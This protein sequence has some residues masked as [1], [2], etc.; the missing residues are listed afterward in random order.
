MAT[1]FGSPH[2]LALL[3]TSHLVNDVL[4]DFTGWVASGAAGVVEGVGTILAATSAVPL[5]AS[6]DVVYDA[7]R[8]VGLAFGLLFV[9]AAVIQAVLRQDLGLLV[10]TLT[11]RLPLALLA[12]GIAIWLVQQALAITD[13]LSAMVL[14]SATGTTQQ[15]IDEL[16][17]LLSGPFSST[18]GF[19]GLLL[20]V[21]AAVVAFILSVELVMR[22]AAV[23][24]AS[25]FLP[26]A[27]AG[28]I[29]PATSHW[30]RRL[31]E[32]IASLVLAKLVIASVLALAIVSI[33]APQGATGLLDGVALLLL[34]TLAP[35]AV[36]R[37]LPFVEAETA[38][39]LEGFSGRAHRGLHSDAVAGLADAVLPSGSG[40]IDLGESRPPLPFFAGNPSGPP[41]PDALAAELAKIGPATAGRNP[42]RGDQSDE[43]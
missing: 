9:A 7:M 30:I 8:R 15:F 41:D 3:G 39:Q 21:V 19:E 10:R 35:F 27:L 16:A 23:E 1:F 12:S 38:A 22:A 40:S 2:S 32:T 18:V 14:G 34:A 42:A 6:F 28:I 24:V 29:W 4:K 26:L 36:F 31:A 17:Q 33:G 25:L 11:V 43:A 20:A 13:A 37:L 5:G